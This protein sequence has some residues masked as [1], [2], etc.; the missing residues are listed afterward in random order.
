MRIRILT[1]TTHNIQEINWIEISCQHWFVLCRSTVLMES[2]QFKSTYVRNQIHLPEIMQH[3]MESWHQKGA[4]NSWMWRSPGAIKKFTNKTISTEISISLM[5]VAGY[6]LKSILKRYYGNSQQ[7]TTIKYTLMTTVISLFSFH[8]HVHVLS[9]SL[10][11]L[12]TTI[13]TIIHQECNCHNFCLS[14]V[15]KQFKI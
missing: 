6:L 2:P 12:H 10:S 8:F 9:L 4:L 1:V 7:V 11:H 13:S 14:K 15:V 5:F 3:E